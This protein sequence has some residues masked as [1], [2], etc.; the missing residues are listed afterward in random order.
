MPNANVLVKIQ[1][2]G[3]W[4]KIYKPSVCIHWL[5]FSCVMYTAV[6]STA[7]SNAVRKCMHK[8]GNPNI[9][10]QPN[11]L[12]SQIFNR[13]WSNNGGKV[14][15]FPSMTCRL[16]IEKFIRKWLLASIGDFYTLKCSFQ[17]S[18][19]VKQSSLLSVTAFLSLLIFSFL[20]TWTVPNLKL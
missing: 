11:I 6:W 13:A 15:C 14:K 1:G 5:I 4:C 10:I 2:F 17:R 20:I 9:N 7:P 19:V 3:F 8:S 18:F 12:Q 16:R